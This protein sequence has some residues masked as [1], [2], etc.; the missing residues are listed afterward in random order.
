MVTLV[1]A[2]KRP[3]NDNEIVVP[4][5]EEEEYSGEQNPDDPVKD[6]DDF[7]W[8]SLGFEDCGKWLFQKING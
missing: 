7:E 4:D 3:A 5:I 6:P 2:A 8:D 1:L